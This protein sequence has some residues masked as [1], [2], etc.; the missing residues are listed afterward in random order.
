MKTIHKLVLTPTTGFV[1]ETHSNAKVLRVGE[2]DLKVVVWVEVDTDLPL[3]KRHFYVVG[4]GHEIPEGAGE[5]YGTVQFLVPSP[6]GHQGRPQ[7]IVLHIYEGEKE[8]DVEP[9]P[10]QGRIQLVKP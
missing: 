2:Q 6:L 1:V 7:E 8:F 3:I 5:Y 9:K 4:T 10:Q